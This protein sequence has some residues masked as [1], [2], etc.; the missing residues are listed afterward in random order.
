M[1]KYI[2]Y[3]MTDV[4]LRHVQNLLQPDYLFMICD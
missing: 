4:L 3:H 2:M 1:V